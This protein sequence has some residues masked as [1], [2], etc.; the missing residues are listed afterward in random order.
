MPGEPVAKSRE[1][2]KKRIES[3]KESKV[4]EGSTPKKTGERKPAPK[5]E[6][7]PASPQ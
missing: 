5:Q 7:A 1:K 6:K 2:V 4:Q 3:E